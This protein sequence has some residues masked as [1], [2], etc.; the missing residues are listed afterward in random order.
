M[1]V[2]YFSEDAFDDILEKENIPDIKLYN[3]ILRKKCC[4]KIYFPKNKSSFF[5]VLEEDV[6]SLEALDVNSLSKLTDDQYLNL[7]YNEDFKDLF[8]DL[9]FNINYFDDIL[10]YDLDDV[11]KLFILNDEEVELKQDIS[12][13]GY[14]VESITSLS[15]KDMTKVA[16]EATATEGN[17]T[18]IRKRVVPGNKR[19]IWIDRFLIHN[20]LFQELTSEFIENIHYSIETAGEGYRSITDVKVKEFIIKIMKFKKED[21]KNKISISSLKKQFCT[22]RGEDNQWCH[23][24]YTKEQ[25]DKV[26]KAFLLQEAKCL[27]S[28]FVYPSLFKIL[29]SDEVFKID[30]S[31]SEDSSKSLDHDVDIN[32]NDIIKNAFESML[33]GFKIRSEV[34]VSKMKAWIKKDFGDRYIITNNFMIKAKT[35]PSILLHPDITITHIHFN[36]ESEYKILCDKVGIVL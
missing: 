12:S 10:C 20:I 15:K 19:M 5:E 32:V 34:K 26:V 33:K 28:I 4:K 22:F 1:S 17:W 18:W 3:L 24:L 11:V 13:E 31:Y 9:I 36:Q 30:V 25:R 14:Q 29:N 35:K 2:V 21:M 16:T 6:V 7:E 27:L 23:Y 8:T